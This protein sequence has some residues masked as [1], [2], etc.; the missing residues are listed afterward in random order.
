MT[1]RERAERLYKKVNKFMLTC[2]SSDGYPIKII[3]TLPHILTMSFVK[4]HRSSV[5]LLIDFIS[6]PL[7][8]LGGRVEFFIQQLHHKFIMQMPVADVQGRVGGLQ[9]HDEQ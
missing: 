3:F 4:T 7:P 2:I 5:I 8:C 9:L 1:S 6:Y